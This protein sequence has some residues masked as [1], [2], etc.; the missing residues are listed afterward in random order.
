MIL[1]HFTSFMSD[2]LEYIYLAF[3]ATSVLLTIV[4]LVKVLVEAIFGG[5][6]S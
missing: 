5:G 4:I 6:R 3:G 1:Y 2:D